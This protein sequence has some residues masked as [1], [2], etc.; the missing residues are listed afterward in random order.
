[1]N[2]TRFRF[3]LASTF[4][5]AGIAAVS[6][7]SCEKES[8][9]PGLSNTS[10]DVEI[11]KVVMPADFCGELLNKPV[12]DAHGSVV[13]ES[14]IYN[15]DKYLV[16]TVYAQNGR[17]IEDMYMNICKTFDEIPLNDWGDPLFDSFNFKILG[18]K[19]CNIRSFKIPLKQVP[20]T[21]MISVMAEIRP[22]IPTSMSEKEASRISRAWIEG[23]TYGGDQKG[24]VFMHSYTYCPGSVPVDPDLVSSN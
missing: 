19:L 18:K 10:A 1:M 24:R 5:A 22:L 13:A 11:K 8:I 12:L 4:F 16:V 7:Y 20:R 23:K 14:M 17:Y 9:T 6:V 2:H 15:T 3:L 21:A